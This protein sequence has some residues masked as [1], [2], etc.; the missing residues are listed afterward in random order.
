[1]INVVGAFAGAELVGV[2]VDALGVSTA[3]SVVGI[4]EAISITLA[5]LSV[6]HHRHLTSLAPDEPNKD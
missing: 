5:V 1:M 4:L 3:I 6:W 2:L